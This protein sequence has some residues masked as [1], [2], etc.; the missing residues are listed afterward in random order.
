MQEQKGTKS[1]KIESS[2][3]SGSSMNENIIKKLNIIF[4][5]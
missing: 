1:I 5:Y 2:E 3:G 4:I